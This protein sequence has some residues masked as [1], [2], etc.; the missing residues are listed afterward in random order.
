MWNWIL[1]VI[2]PFNIYKIFKAIKSWCEKRKKK[3]QEIIDNQAQVV[4]TRK[5]I[6]ADAKKSKEFRN[7]VLELADGSGAAT[8]QNN[9]KRWQKVKSIYLKDGDKEF[10]MNFDQDESQ[11]M[12]D[13]EQQ[14]TDN[15]I[16]ET[17]STN[18]KEVSRGESYGTNFYNKPRKIEEKHTE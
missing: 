8:N 4:I 2:N 14:L 10:S 13:K 9:S 5:K 12:N 16:D 17:K 18:E 1:K 3:H 6:D 11:T 15:I 7:T